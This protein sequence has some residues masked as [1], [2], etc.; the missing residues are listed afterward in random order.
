MRTPC[1]K[2]L[3]CWL[4]PPALN[5][6]RSGLSPTLRREVTPESKAAQVQ[7]WD[8]TDSPGPTPKYCYSYPACSVRALGAV[9]GPRGLPLLPMVAWGFKEVPVC[10]AIPSVSTSA[11][12]TGGKTSLPP[13]LSSAPSSSLSPQG[14][15]GLTVDPIRPQIVSGICHPPGSTEKDSRAPSR[16]AERV[17]VRED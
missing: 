3:G 7:S 10:R 14:A 1:L 4:W 15:V 8:W 17:E 12:P 5:A 2:S 6:D 11:Q 16:I 13:P 9:R